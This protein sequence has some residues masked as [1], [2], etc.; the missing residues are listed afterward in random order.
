MHASWLNGEE[1]RTGKILEETWLVRTQKCKSTRRSEKEAIG[2]DNIKQLLLCCTSHRLEQCQ[3]QVQ[4]ARGTSRNRSLV[5]QWTELKHR[6]LEGIAGAA[7]THL[8]VRWSW[9]LV[10][11]P[12]VKEKNSNSIMSI[13][14]SDYGFC[15]NRSHTLQVA[16]DFILSSC[17]CFA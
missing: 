4:G 11:I 8:V 2:L 10:H 5:W 17:F 13:N 14:F 16:L 1:E 6:P 15:Q 12:G 7:L 3:A 9:W